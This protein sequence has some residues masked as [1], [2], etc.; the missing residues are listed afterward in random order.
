VFV[1]IVKIKEITFFFDWANLERNNGG[2]TINNSA[3]IL[4]VIGTILL[5][6]GALLDI[7]KN[8]LIWGTGSVITI[9][10]IILFRIDPFKTNS[11]SK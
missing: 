3:H 11:K 6:M 5:I 7:T 4:L 9:F 2:K 10:M 1:V 8:P